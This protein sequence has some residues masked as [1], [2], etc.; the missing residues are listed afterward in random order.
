MY[1][2][3]FLVSQKRE[4]GR[5]VLA[6]S[7]IVAQVPFSEINSQPVMHTRV[8]M[9][10]RLERIKNVSTT[11]FYQINLKIKLFLN[12]KVVSELSHFTVSNIC[13]VLR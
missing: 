7:E 13:F 1:V 4:V 8:Q 6:K 11:P 9:H 12:A 10:P 2:Y 3:S 5:I